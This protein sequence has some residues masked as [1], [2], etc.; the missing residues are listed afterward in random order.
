MH[1]PAPI[2]LTLD[3]QVVALS[4]QPIGFRYTPHDDSGMGSRSSVMTLT[5]PAFLRRYPQHVQQPRKHAVLSYGL[6]APRKTERLNLARAA[7]HQRPI[8]ATPPLSWQAYYARHPALSAVHACPVCGEA[9]SSI[10]RVSHRKAGRHLRPSA[11]NPHMHRRLTL[12]AGCRLVC[13]VGYPHAPA[14][15]NLASLN[16]DDPRRSTVAASILPSRFIDCFP[17]RDHIEST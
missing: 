11:R 1:I 17:G 13:A 3:G 2:A 15:L 4:G 6:Y 7:F 16:A 12:R 9:F 14:I 8:A 10:R 5:S